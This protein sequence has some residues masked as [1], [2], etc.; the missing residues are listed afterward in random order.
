MTIRLPI[1]RN[2]ALVT[3]A[4]I[5]LTG[6]PIEAEASI[7]TD[8]LFDGV[9]NKL[10]DNDWDAGILTNG[11]GSTTLDVGDI[12]FGMYEIQQVVNNQ[13]TSQINLRSTNT[14]TG[15][16]AQR[17]ATKDQ[18]GGQFAGAAATRFTF[19][20]LT[21]L[22]YS[23]LAAS[24]SAL[25]AVRGSS[26]SMF[27]VYDDLGPPFVNGNAGSINSSLATA[28][29]GTLLWEFGFRDGDELFVADVNTDVLASTGSLD[30][31]GWINLT[32]TTAAGAATG[33]SF[34]DHLTVPAPPDG[35]GP[36][37]TAVL[38]EMQI[39]GTLEPGASPGNFAIATDTDIFVLPKFVPEPS[40]L[41]VFLGL[42]ATAGLAVARSNR[43]AS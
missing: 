12:L 8:L 19:A 37:V 15:V 28:T 29:N 43:Q 30:F 27:F 9:V 7:A 26:D 1:T 3:V 6:S 38:S 2:L 35:N 25:P 5:V 33:V 23:A 4:L 41:L 13:N 14:F 20:P 32:Y 11:G 31:V 34:M 42:I 24:F 16:F 36:P 39:H 22:E 17:V 40:S 10:E 21:D 18:P